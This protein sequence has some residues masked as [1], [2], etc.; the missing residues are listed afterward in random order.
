MSLETIIAGA[1]VWLLPILIAIT[2]HEAAHAYVAYKLGDDTAKLLGRVT[3][4]PLKHVDPVGTVFLPAFLV[5]V[6]S[7]FV[8][9]WA[10][11]VPVNF[12]RLRRPRRDVI[13]VAGAGP[14]INVVI[15][16]FSALLIYVVP[17]LPQFSADFVQQNLINSLK[18]N[19][20]LAVFNML[21]I[22]PLDG[23]RILMSILPRSFAHY[24]AGLERH[25]LL[26][27][28]VLVFFLPQLGNSLNINL[29]LFQVLIMEPS[30]ALINLII[31][32]VGG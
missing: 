25:G 30:R 26:I 6:G 27:I 8:F 23:G 1:T 12:A 13:L 31:T 19:V 16:F 3:F 21:P 24:V 4:N 10:K 32:L 18:L 9:G 22:P 7:P 20:V 2:F 28:I 5:V 14:A 17:L 15:A 11:P 29:D